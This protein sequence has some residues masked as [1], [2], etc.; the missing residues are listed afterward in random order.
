MSISRPFD[1]LRRLPR[2]TGYLTKKPAFGARVL[3]HLAKRRMGGAPLGICEYAVTMNCN[4]TCPKC[5][6]DRMIDR[7]RKRMLPEKIRDLA[8][9]IDR[10]GVYEVNFTGGEPTLDKK[11]EDIV[12]MFH[13]EHTFLGLNTHGGFLDHRRILTLR[14]AGLDLFKFSM[15][16]PIAAE[17]NAGRGIPGLLEHIFDLLRFIDETPGVRGHFCVTATR[18][19]IETGKLAKAVELAAGA[20]ATIGFVIPTPVGRWE[21]NIEILL[22]PHHFDVILKLARHPA[23]FLP[24]FTGNGKDNDTSEIYVTCFGDVLPNPYVQISFGNINDEPLEAILARIDQWPEMHGAIKPALLL[25][26]ERFVT[27]YIKPLSDAPVLPLRYDRHPN[28]HLA[29]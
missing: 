25:E 6:S 5:S 10:L 20:N 21:D 11:L 24:A 16:S 23:V 3:T 29:G 1:I 17:H 18:E 8:D 22:E 13:P 26:N 28:I 7:T 19:M 2:F 27:T 12:A 9:T 14:D 15:D 4:A